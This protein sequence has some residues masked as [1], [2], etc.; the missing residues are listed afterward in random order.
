[1]TNSKVENMIDKKC[2]FGEKT[3]VVRRK[4]SAIL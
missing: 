2:V 1:M 4:K 3:K